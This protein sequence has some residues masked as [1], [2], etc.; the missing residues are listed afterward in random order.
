MQD[1]DL[2]NVKN[3][4]HMQIVESVWLKLSTMHLCV[5]VLF[6]SQKKYHKKFSM[7]FKISTQHYQN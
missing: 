2:L 6:P 5:K 4:M 7:R 1:F 3:H